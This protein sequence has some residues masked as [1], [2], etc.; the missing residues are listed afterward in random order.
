MQETAD[1]DYVLFYDVKILI[2]ALDVCTKTLTD[3]KIWQWSYMEGSK[4]YDDFEN[5]ANKARAA[6]IIF[7]GSQ[8]P[9]DSAL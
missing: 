4:I 8:N 9:S 3:D 7:F 5:A 1:G 2:N 6:K